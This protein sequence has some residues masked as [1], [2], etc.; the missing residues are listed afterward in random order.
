MSRL[1][2]EGS[3]HITQRKETIGL[4]NRV[5]AKVFRL[6]NEAAYSAQFG[7]LGGWMAC[8]GLP[9]TPA[10]RPCYSIQNE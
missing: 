9:W 2:W 5:T 3:L 7:R 1:S 10:A 4:G 6:P 8:F